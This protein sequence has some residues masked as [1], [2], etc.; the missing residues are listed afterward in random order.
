MLQNSP[1]PTLALDVLKRRQDLGWA[2][3]VAGWAAERRGDLAAAIEFYR[4]G[5]RPSLFA[6]N[7]VKFRTHWF[8]N[9]FGKFSAAQALAFAQPSS[10]ELTTDGY[11][12][13]SWK[14]TTPRSVN[15]SATT[16][17]PKPIGRRASSVTATPIT[18][19]TA[20]AGTWA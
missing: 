16:G 12:N 18:P 14:T 2:W 8:A 19:T 17:W 4:H 5:V 9:G 7:T 20:P 6:D 10:A 15:E 11:C 1:E 3:D 13:C